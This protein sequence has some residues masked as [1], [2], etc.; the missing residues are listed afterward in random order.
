MRPVRCHLLVVL[1]IAANS[2]DVTVTDQPLTDA[3]VGIEQRLGDLL[4]RSVAHL[5]GL[6]Q[7]VALSM[8]CRQPRPAESLGIAELI[9][10]LKSD[11]SWRLSFTADSWHDNEATGVGLISLL[12]SLQSH[13]HSLAACR[14]YSALLRTTGLDAELRLPAEY[15]RCA[16]EQAEN[17]E[18]SL[19]ADLRVHPR[20]EVVGEWN[21]SRIA[22]APLRSTAWSCDALLVRNSTE[23][24]DRRALPH[25][26]TA[27]SH[28]NTRFVS[29]PV[30]L[31]Q[32]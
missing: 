27:S 26:S 1:C 17:V 11:S 32:A 2:R 3:L 29:L 9:R 6:G 23:R 15:D 20:F 19:W 13:D 7:R 21:G 14:V 12:H 22:R 18:K 25:A 8:A 10:W 4:R 16:R 31:Q 28:T 30:R 24:C 5:T